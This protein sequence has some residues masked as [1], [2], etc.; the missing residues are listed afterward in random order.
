[1][2]AFD[3]FRGTGTLN[4]WLG[5]AALALG[6]AGCSSV[7]VSVE[8]GFTALFDGTH[9]NRWTLLGNAN[10]RLQD[11]LA[12]AELGSGYLVSKEVYTDFHLK[13]EFWV[14]GPANSGIFFRCADPK[15][16]GAEFCYEANIF[17]TRADPTYGTASI[18]NFAK[19][20]GEHKAGNRWNSMEVIAQ[21][22]RL[23]VIFN[24]VQTVDVQDAKYPKGIIAL[25]YGGGVVK[26]RK[27]QV[28]T[29]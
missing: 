27:V 8:P 19:V 5:A 28:K 29:L 9:L 13:A 21:G 4:R 12:Q 23:R 17:D 7:P 25:Q 11:G 10:W 22:P 15:R 24:G 20:S 1:M 16:V 3:R 2:N 26:F 6:I 14:D 18:V